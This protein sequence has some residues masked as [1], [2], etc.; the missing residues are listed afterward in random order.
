MRRLLGVMLFAGWIASFLFQPRYDILL[1]TGQV[2][3]PKNNIN[4]I[5]DVD[6]LNGLSI[7]DGKKIEPST[8]AKVGDVTAIHATSGQLDIHVHAYEETAV[9]AYTGD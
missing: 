1:K 8:A 5:Q 4:E 3:D 6:I 9:K 2:I 7:A